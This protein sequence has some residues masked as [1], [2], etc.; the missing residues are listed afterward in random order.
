MRRV[1]R[2]LVFLHLF[3][4]V[5]LLSSCATRH[6]I[7]GSSENASSEQ[8]LASSSSTSSSSITQDIKTIYSVDAN[9]SSSL[10]LVGAPNRI[11]S[12]VLDESEDVKVGSETTAV[13]QTAQKNSFWG[14]GKTSYKAKMEIPSSKGKTT[15]K[16]K[17]DELPPINDKYSLETTS[18]IENIQFKPDESSVFVLMPKTSDYVKRVKDG[19][20]SYVRN[21]VEY[22]EFLK[23]DGDTHSLLIAT[24]LTPSFKN[25][26][27]I[28]RTLESGKAFLAEKN[29]RLDPNFDVKTGFIEHLANNSLSLDVG[30]DKG[31][32]TFN[33]QKFTYRVSNKALGE[34]SFGKVLDISITGPSG[35]FSIALKKQIVEKEYIPNLHEEIGITEGMS[36]HPNS[37]QFFGAYKNSKNEYYIAMEK[38]DGS[39]ENLREKKGNASQIRENFRQVA[40]VLR[41]LKE[42]GYAHR[43]IKLENL[44]IGSDGQIRVIDYG[45]S[46][47]N[48]GDT[49]LDYGSIFSVTELAP[50]WLP[51]DYFEIFKEFRI[52]D[53]LNTK[54]LKDMSKIRQGLETQDQS[55]SSAEVK[56]ES[57][58]KIKDDPFVV[59]KEEEASEGINYGTSFFTPLT[60]DQK[61]IEAEN[62]HK[63]LEMEQ[64]S[65]AQQTNHIDFSTIQEKKDVFSLGISYLQM[66]MKYVGYEDFELFLANIGGIKL[67]KVT[68]QDF[69][70]VQDGEAIRNY[71]TNPSNDATIKELF[72]TMTQ[73]DK[74]IIMSMIH[75]DA[76]KRPSFEELNQQIQ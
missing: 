56:Q 35:Q 17:S 70:I 30:S 41:S 46:G 71:F 64:A 21:G 52:Q 25:V 12:V 4:S 43:D 16:F 31:N 33:G 54:T 5:S 68:T 75:P 14:F 74:N 55:S 28:G 40:E 3:C 9:A 45:I 66:K 20:G 24:K 34:G 62:A 51:R 48:Q 67:V 65:L 49:A 42:A 27:D 59:P 13:V 73:E 2:S 32:F 8:S 26:D 69:R 58:P 72:P 10:Q 44:M 22:K 60:E 63:F 15:F 39:W 47:K 11:I 7:E 37:I 57:V 76:K 29:Y 19:N 38:L 6:N 36:R 61:R 23:S 18:N 50:L 53:T 1:S